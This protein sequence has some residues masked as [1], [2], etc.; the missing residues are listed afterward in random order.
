MKTQL[1]QDIGESGALARPDGPH[2][3]PP[4]PPSPPPPPRDP[5]DWKGFADGELSMD[6]FDEQGATR[7]HWFVRWGRKLATSGLVLTMLVLLAAAGIWFYNE[8]KVETAMVVL[9]QQSLPAPEAPTPAAPAP[10]PQPVA[11][12]P[13]PKQAP[14][15][16][17]TV[18]R[19]A[20]APSPARQLD[21]TLKQCRAAGYHAAQCIERGCRMTKYGLACRG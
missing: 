17:T 3:P 13:P 9:A 10:A 20:P 2:E 8:T 15:P 7:P 14:L 18:A 5:A 12:T 16:K 21:E 11:A 4:L 1:L 19:A 6:S